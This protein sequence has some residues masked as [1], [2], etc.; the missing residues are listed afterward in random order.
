MGENEFKE[1]MTEALKVISSQTEF[2]M[3]KA[4]LREKIKG[5]IEYVKH[6][7]S[8]CMG[9]SDIEKKARVEE[10][11]YVLCILEECMN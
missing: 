4:K 3:V 5:R 2:T 8:G 11:N 6:K 10:L 7:L 1:G 9:Y